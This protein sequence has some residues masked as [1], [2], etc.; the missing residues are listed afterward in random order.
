MEIRGIIFNRV[1]VLV[2]SLIISVAI[3]SI[4]ASKEY[5]KFRLAKLEVELKKDNL[6][7]KNNLIAKV[8]N[9][10]EVNK[11]LRD[12][13]LGRIYD[14]PPEGTNFENY[15]AIIEHYAKGRVLISSYSIEGKVESGDRTSKENGRSSSSSKSSFSAISAN[16][17]ATGSFS[18]FLSFLGDIE[19]SIPIIDISSIDISKA[20]VGSDN[21]EFSKNSPLNY[22][23]RFVFYHR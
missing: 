15:V 11:D 17:S 8:K 2:L 1:L 21:G 6:E 9:Y 16:F 23:V 7:L 3:L 22:D 19:K 14:L 4:F 13:D 12:E 18:N 5:D 10:N 20:K